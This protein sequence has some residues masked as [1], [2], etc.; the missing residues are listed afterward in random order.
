MPV[1]PPIDPTILQQKIQKIQP[2]LN[3]FN[4]LSIHVAVTDENAYILYANKLAAE[5]TGYHDSQEVLGK[6]PGDLWGGR[7]DP[8]FFTEMWK[9]IKIDKRRYVGNVKNMK[10]NGA[11]YWVSLQI[12]P[13]LNTHDEVIYFVALEPDVDIKPEYLE[14]VY[15]MVEDLK[16]EVL[17]LT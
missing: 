7:M 4:D 8:Q 14:K 17:A 11:E 6:N 5:K 12:T 10:K 2:L 15:A 16:K 13:I 1:R 3:R 9:T